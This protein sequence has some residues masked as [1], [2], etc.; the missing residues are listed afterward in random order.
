MYA[1]MR[2]RLYLKNFMKFKFL[3]LKYRNIFWESV[4]KVKWKLE[5]CNHHAFS[6]FENSANKRNF[7]FLS[8]KRS[9]G[10]YRLLNSDG[11]LCKR[12][13]LL[14]FIR[15]RLYELWRQ[16]SWT[17]VMLAHPIFWSLLPL[18]YNFNCFNSLFI[19]IF[20]AIRKFCFFDVRK[21]IR[22]SLKHTGAVKLLSAITRL[23]FS[24]KIFFVHILLFVLMPWID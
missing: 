24:Q 16:F 23:N 20:L 1:F 12:V 10:I 14:N 11:V 2:I 18:K 6:H 22:T 7:K 13:L 5:L 4:L 17:R 9:G 19:F 15:K 3:R 21:V 8:E